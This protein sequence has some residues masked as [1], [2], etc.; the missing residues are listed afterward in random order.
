MKFVR[1]GSGGPEGLEASGL[2]GPLLPLSPGRRVSL[3]GGSWDPHRRW[4]LEGGGDGP[5][6]RAPS[7][8]GICGPALVLPCPCASSACQPESWGRGPRVWPP[9]RV[10]RCVSGGAGHGG[11]PRVMACRGGPCP[12]S[13]QRGPWARMWTGGGMGPP[14]VPVARGHGPWLV[15]FGR[16]LRADSR[17]RLGLST[18][19]R[20]SG[21]PVSRPPLPPAAAGSGRR[22]G[23][24]VSDPSPSPLHAGRCAVAS[25]LQL[26]PPHFPG[27]VWGPAQAARAFPG[28]GRGCG[29]PAL[30]A[31]TFASA[32]VGAGAAA[33]S[34]SSGGSANVLGRRAGLGPPTH[35]S[36]RP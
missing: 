24:G 1:A 33:A 20:L 32:S 10:P 27:G 23:P 17:Q 18:G 29:P 15:D 14:P 6:P 2:G 31:V 3:A 35:W 12:V 26:T 9:P 21:H 28:Q 34:D 19:S 8:G 5:P 16:A 30:R 7:G 4:N 11:A 13:S 22:W 25:R 36:P